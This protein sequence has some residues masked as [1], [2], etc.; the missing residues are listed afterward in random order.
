MNKYSGISQVGK[1]VGGYVRVSTFEQAEK[2]TSIDEQ[3]KVIRQ[4][5]K[6][7]GWQLI[8]I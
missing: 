4:E 7:R 2:G 5:C 8:E 6:R 1:Q 3:K